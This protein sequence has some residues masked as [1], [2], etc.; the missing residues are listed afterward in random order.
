LQSLAVGQKYGVGHKAKLS[1]FY[2]HL[3]QHASIPQTSCA[4]CIRIA[5][6]DDY[7]LPASVEAQDDY[8]PSIWADSFLRNVA[9]RPV[10]L[11]DPITLVWG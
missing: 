11:T 7:S 1:P 6:A 2:S 4:I 10:T 5:V 3:T 9:R 8:L